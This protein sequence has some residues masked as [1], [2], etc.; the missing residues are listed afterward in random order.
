[1]P[2]DCV[3]H[4]SLAEFSIGADN[5]CLMLRG[6]YRQ[7]VISCSCQASGICCPALITTVTQHLSYRGVHVV[8]KQESH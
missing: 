6:P 5:D 1:V 2:A 3:P 7:L 4:A 8:I